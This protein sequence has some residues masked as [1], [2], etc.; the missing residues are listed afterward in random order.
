MKQPS[1][2]GLIKLNLQFLPVIAVLA[3]LG[4]LGAGCRNSSV[5]P[6]PGPVSL[7]PKAPSQSG[8]PT[9]DFPVAGLIC[10]PFDSSLTMPG[11]KGGHKV[12]LSWNASAPADAKHSTAVGYCLYRGTT[13]KAPP[14]ERVNVVPFAGTK[15]A[16]D[17]VESGKT[18]YYVVRAISARGVT[19]LVSKPAPASIPRSPRNPNLAQD[20]T[21]AC[22][23]PAGMK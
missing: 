8:T 15:C 23:V 17:L 19:S 18:Y 14:T 11:V 20:S 4:I 1:A 21:P 7:G 2:V 5:P 3:V 10:P 12:I 13:Q 6:K 16:D 9:G 22:R